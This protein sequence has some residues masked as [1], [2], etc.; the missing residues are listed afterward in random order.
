[1]WNSY[2]K[3]TLVA[4][5]GGVHLIF[6]HGFPRFRIFRSC[7]WEKLFKSGKNY[8]SSTPLSE[9]GWWFWIWKVK[10]GWWFWVKKVKRG[11]SKFQDSG[12]AC[13]LRGIRSSR[14]GL[15]SHKG[16]LFSCIY[17][18]ENTNFQKFSPAVGHFLRLKKYMSSQFSKFFT[19]CG[20]LPNFNF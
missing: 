13:V 8:I 9:G 14:G 3:K 18:Y 5:T 10:G 7:K 6:P 2:W 11:V 20:L 15:N 4:D 16:N 1:M 12:G 19:C 17:I